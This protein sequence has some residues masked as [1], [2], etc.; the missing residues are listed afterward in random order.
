[1]GLEG[2][3]ASSDYILGY[4]GTTATLAASLGRI[5]RVSHEL[6]EAIA[7]DSELEAAA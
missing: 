6:L 4:D 5:Q 1:M 7:P 2:I 3:T